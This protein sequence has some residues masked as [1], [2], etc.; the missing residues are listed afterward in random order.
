MAR[1]LITA[2][3]INFIWIVSAH[4]VIANPDPSTFADDD[5]SRYFSPASKVLGVEILDL[6][7]SL[8]A[9]STFGFYFKNDP[10]N[11]VVIFDSSDQ[12]SA[13]PPQTAVID[14]GLGVVLDID[15]GLTIQNIFTGSGPIGFFLG[16]NTLVPTIGGLGIATDPLLNINGLDLVSTFPVLA[17]PDA[18]LLAFDIPLPQQAPLVLGLHAIE[19]IT[20]ATPPQTIPEPA[21]LALMALPIAIIWRLRKR[22]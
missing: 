11:P 16:I 6:F 2:V 10:S 19:G 14:F 12:S 17:N 4:A 18:Y 20:P 7:G 21:T 1:K 22:R 9:G 3:F 8:G 5:G 15:G 13:L